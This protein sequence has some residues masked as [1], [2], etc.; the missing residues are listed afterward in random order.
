[1]YGFS[2]IRNVVVLVLILAVSLCL[3]LPLSASCRGCA[4]SIFFF[5]LLES[6]T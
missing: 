5:I 1:M 3:F 6:D 2:P 4:L